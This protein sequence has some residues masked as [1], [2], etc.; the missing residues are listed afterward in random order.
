M[1]IDACE[2]WFERAPLT[3]PYSIAYESVDSVELCYV[4]LASGRHAGH[5]C[6]SPIPEVT[7]ED[8][9]GCRAALERA[10]EELRAGR[11][12][13]AA[14][15]GRPAAAAAIDMALHDLRA[16]SVGKPLAAILGRVHAPLPTSITIGIKPALADVL[17]EAREFLGRGFRSIKL[18]IGL[19]LDED[20]ERVAKLRELAGAR[21]TLTID[22][23][24]GFRPA[25]LPR[26]FR[27]LD[28]H[29]IAFLEQPLPPAFDDECARLPERDRARLA[30][31][32]SLLSPDDARAHATARRAGIFNIKLMKCGGPTPAL[33]IARVAHE[34]GVALMWGCSDESRLGIAAALHAALASPAT[35]HL[36]LDGHLDLAR[37]LGRGGFEIVDGALVPGDGPGLGVEVDAWP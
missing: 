3:R 33:E 21:T 18:K 14:L 5:G 1:R 27:A 8:I 7:G 2:L 37:D 23:N 6:A 30:L 28:E 13:T 34:H 12:A 35:R 10:A 15:A 29:D 20:L 25:D 16:R 24:Q 4:R 17:E 32:E 26:L 11:P 31:D 36:D 9:A 22:A 19:D